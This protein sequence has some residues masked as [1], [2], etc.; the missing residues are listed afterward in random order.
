MTS[1]VTAE[2]PDQGQASIGDAL[3]DLPSLRS[4]FSQQNSGRFIGTAGNN[5]LDLRGLGTS[6]TLVLVNG[7]RHVTSSAGDFIVDVNTIPQDLIERID[8]VTGGEAAVY[9]SDAVA[10]VVNFILK[11]DFDGIRLRAQD[12]V[13]K[14]GD[15]PVEFVT[16]TAGRNFA[17]G[18][19]NIAINLEYTHAAQ[20]LTR[21][22]SHFTNPCGF[23]PTD[24][25]SVAD[26]GNGTPDNTFV[27]G[28]RLAGLTQGGAIGV[29]NNA[30][31]TLAFNNAG[32]LVLTT[33]Q[34]S[35]LANNGDITSTDPLTG[36][37]TGVTL[38][39]T[40]ALAVGQNRYTANVLA[41]FDVSDAFKPFI[42]AKYVRQKVFSEQQATFFEGS[43]SSF[44]GGLPVPNLRCNNPFLNSQALATGT[45]G[46]NRYNV[47]FGGREEVDTRTTYRIVGGVEG[48]FYGNWHYEV[49]ANYGH[50]QADNAQTR[51]L[52]LADQ[53]GNP[54]GFSLAI[55]AVRNAAGQIVCRV[56]QVTV[57]VPG[58]VPLNVFGFGAPSPAAVAFSTTTS[59]LFSK[60]SELDLLAFVSGDTGH[61][62]KLPGGPVGFSIGT[63]YR[64]ETAEDHADPVSASGGTFFNAFAPF[65]PP[66]LTVKEVFGEL[67]LPLLKDLPFAHELS[68]S[69]AARYSDYNTSAGH[70]WAWNVSGI[71]SP[72]SDIRFRANYSK[73]V[74]VPTLNDLFSPAGVN[75]EFISDPCNQTNIN[76]GTATRAANCAALGVP[77]TI[78]ANSPCVGVNGAVAGGPFFNCNASGRNVEIT[79][80]GNPRLKAETGRSLTVGGVFT[81]RFLQGFSVTIDYFDIKVTNLIATLTG[82]QILT[83]CVDAP[84]INNQFCPLLFPRDQFGLFPVPALLSAGVNFAKQTSKGVDFD[85]AYRHTFGNGHI[86]TLRGIATWTRERLNFTDPTDPTL[87]SQQLGDL[88]DPVFSGSLQAGYQAGPF[89]VNYT[90]RYIG[91]TTIFPVEDTSSVQGRPPQDPDV[92]SPISYPAIFYHDIQFG[93][94]INTRFRAYFGVDNIFNTLPPFGLTGTGAGGAIYSNIGRF[95]YGGIEVNF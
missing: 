7:R 58:C 6:R 38:N 74:R 73:S 91:K 28:V 52:L 23:E 9:G 90:L 51:D 34:H 80:A 48:D 54:A 44:F 55:D 83:S 33:P 42:E 87:F 75:F 27:C 88:G 71:Y 17:D 47:D 31:T 76:N 14:Y 46:L 20:L 70:T 13:S 8:I 5:F 30:G 72:V 25:P 63:E 26:S 36:Q 53:N 57:T 68:V 86:V 49:S 11:R 78:A 1:V 94:K 56:N 79:S 32:N 29:L 60:A 37:L 62:F 22:R 39:E 84:T 59:N 4:T 35:F 81:P 40:G 16:L 93:A 95:F 3:N 61:W 82:Q 10:G 24:D 12:G 69:G 77:T 64:R 67:N 41:H 92:S 65:N 2:L 21:D 45:F 19:G 66:A 89:S 43:L 85:L 18:R 15:R 50:Y